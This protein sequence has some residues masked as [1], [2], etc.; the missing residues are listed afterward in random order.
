ME[1][2]GKKDLELHGRNYELIHVPPGK[3]H[4]DFKM[5]DFGKF[6]I[7]QYPQVKE[8]FVVSSDTDLDNLCKHLMAQELTVYRVRR[9]DSIM[10]IFNSKTEQT[11]NY[12]LNPLPL[13]PPLGDFINQV[14]EIIKEEQLKVNKIWIKAGRVYQLFKLKYKLD[15]SQILAHYFPGKKSKN[16]WLKMKNDF[17]IHSLDN[18]N[19]VYLS[20]F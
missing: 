9:Q 13:I 15:I 6:I 2:T 5:I 20:I 17:V 3:N 18:S 4:A 16:F 1:T 8:V 10:S 19:Q 11:H 7:T 14:K 12:F